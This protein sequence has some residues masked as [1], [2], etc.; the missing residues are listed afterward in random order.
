MKAAGWAVAFRAL[1]AA[2]MV[3]IQGYGVRW[4]C[5]ILLPLFSL[6]AWMFFY[7]SGGSVA[8]PTG[9]SEMMAPSQPSKVASLS[10]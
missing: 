10:G 1:F 4:S 5:L 2:A 6:E 8:D 9:Q 7:A 3:L